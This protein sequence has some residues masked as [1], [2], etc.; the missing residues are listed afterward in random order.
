[1]P[2][3]DVLDDFAASLQPRLA[4]DLR[5]DAMTR[6][7]YASDASVCQIQPVGVL[8]PK[9]IDDVQAALEAAVRFRIPVLPRGGGS[10]LSGQAVG[11]A[12]VIDFTK[13]LD[14]ILEV[15]A[16]VG[17]VRV[18]PGLVLDHLNAHLAPLGWMVGPDPASSNRATL[19]GMVGTNATGT[20]SILY[21]NVINHIQSIR[22]LLADGSDATFGPLDADAWAAAARQD[23]FEG[24]LYRGLDHL[25]RTRGH[26]V[27]RDTPVHWRRNSGYRL[28]YL[29][30]HVHTV[31]GDI[32]QGGVRNVA[33]LLCGSEGTLAV[34]TELTLAL[35]PRPKQTALGIV[36]FRT[37]AE[38]LRAVTAIL[39]TSPSAIELFDGTAIE[40]VRHTPGYAHRLTFVEGRP[41]AVLLTEYYGTSDAELRDRLDGLERTG[42]GYTVVRATTPEQIRDVWAIRKESLGLI[43][44]F[45]GDY[46]PVALIE[47]ASVPVEHLADYIEALDRLL[48]ETGTKAVYY[49]HASAGCLHVRP[50]LN[51]K[52]TRE[53]ERMRAI[54]E[55]SMELVRKYGG[56]VASEHGDGIVRGWLNERFLGPDLCDVYRDLKKL[57]DPEHLLNPGK[58][59][60]T[61]RLG[62]DLRTGPP[63]ALLPILE[64]LDWSEDGSFVQA[65]EM[66]NGNGACRKLGGGTMCPSFMVTREEEHS[67]RG[68][69]NALRA[70]MT[71]TLPPEDL[72]GPRLYEVMDLCIQCK[73]CKTECPSNVDMAKIKTEWLNT[74]WEANGISRRAR[75]FANQ[76]KL[77]RR[78]NG[79]AR[80][81]FVNWINSR[82]SMRTLLERTLG[83]SEKRVLPPFAREPFTT[84]F[85]RQNWKSD[86]PAVV[87][88]ADTF[89]NYHHP[90]VARAAAEFLH[91]VGL[92]VL[93]PDAAACCGRPLLS[94]GL[95]TEAQEG[96]L[97]AVDWLYPYAEQGLP[98]VGLE[99]SCILTF[100]DEFLTLLPGDLRAR[101][102]AEVALTFEEYVAQLADAGTLDAV[103]WT[104]RGREVLL[105]GHCH[106]KALVGTGPAERCLAL[107][108]NYTVS[109]VDSGCCGMA[110]AFGY[111]KE[112]YDVSI[113]MAGRRL[114]PAVHAAG[115]DTIIAAAGAS[116]HAQ[117]KDTT[118]RHA[119]H[120][121]E[122]LRDA[123]A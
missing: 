36:H 23:G 34:S 35:T 95:V 28:E 46:K 68:R 114:A 104:H 6:T 119:L 75:L 31:H 117:I 109:T 73:A 122:I 4:G 71:G 21:G 89:N 100:R 63:Y 107:P 16:E 27:A 116:C 42:L 25:L 79:G 38:A 60:D 2:F 37:R 120:P 54:S 26:I 47:D 94:K 112:H 101:R 13:H 78:I 51:T 53:V 5:L 77:A 44:G 45:K 97:E 22:A 20:H 33:Q 98:I 84:W 111:E 62:E 14:A 30:D 12:L 69:A 49:A 65:V 86:G 15:D 108:P 55:G 3:A 39:E 61:P 121:A 43:M 90:G 57:F 7:L 115:N 58:I 118:G 11:A 93:V 48:T 72:T 96:A 66:C 8:I 59:I 106:Q 91:R 87:L 19:G 105:H 83:I 32:A 123:L 1:M 76:P 24:K 113:R 70:V 64:T 40:Q 80:A 81:R 56:A 88:F 103:A 50:F 102:L 99:P 74:Y 17:R 41:G 85:A 29:L 18:Q 92:R 52:D 67:T 82:V 10:S 110:G 9:H